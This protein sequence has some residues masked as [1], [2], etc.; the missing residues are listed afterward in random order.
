MHPILP[1]CLAAYRFLVW[2]VKADDEKGFQQDRMYDRR[3][4]G[5]CKCFVA[6]GSRSGTGATIRHTWRTKLDRWFPRSMLLCSGSIR[7]GWAIVIIMRRVEFDFILLQLACFLI[8]RLS[9]GSLGLDLR[10]LSNFRRRDTSH[11]RKTNANLRIIQ[12]QLDRTGSDSTWHR[13]A[14]PWLYNMGNWNLLFATPVYW[15]S[16]QFSQHVATFK[17]SS[18]HSKHQDLRGLRPTVGQQGA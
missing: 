6:F 10:W 11:K 7:E 14:L 13:S 1:I 12:W 9:E 4:R 2:R 17:L 18:S 15:M 8:A 3:P 16:I 5:K